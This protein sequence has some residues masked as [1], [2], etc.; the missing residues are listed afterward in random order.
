MLKIPEGKERRSSERNTESDS[1]KNSLCE[2]SRKTML[3]TC[4]SA[5]KV[6]R[7]WLEVEGRQ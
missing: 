2:N 4:M 1:W 6:L 7:W 3:E 5:E